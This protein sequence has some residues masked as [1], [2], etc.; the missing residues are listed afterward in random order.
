[1]V[2]NRPDSS[3]AAAAMGDDRGMTKR[4]GWVLL[5]TSCSWALTDKLPD[6]YDPKAGHEPRCS[7]GRAPMVLDLIFAGLSVVS[8]SIELS[9]ERQNV[10]NAGFID[11][12][13]GLMFA[14]SA[15]SGASWT[16]H[17]REAVE[18][19][20]S[21]PQVQTPE[22]PNDELQ[23]LRAEKA[24]RDAAELERLRAEHNALTDAGVTVDATGADAQ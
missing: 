13:V 20:E 18:A 24:A 12:G 15:A 2:E 7:T 17:C 11:L 6:G 1:V 10:K 4:L 9:D 21:A 3:N 16:G 8:S 14:I 22:S 19:Y 5:M 23:R